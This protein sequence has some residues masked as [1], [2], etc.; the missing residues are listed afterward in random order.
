MH[1]TARELRHFD[2][3]QLCVLVARAYTRSIDRV[4]LF[5]GLQSSRKRR[6]AAAAESL[7]L[8]DPLP[9]SSICLRAW[10]RVA[11]L[12]VSWPLCT[13]SALVPTSLIPP[14]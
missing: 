6:T 2:C 1:K 11:A 9:H 4:S 7:A 14:W 12:A 5:P 10:L 13:P 8:S 3:A